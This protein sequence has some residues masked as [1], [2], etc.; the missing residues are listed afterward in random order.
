V[1]VPLKA[2]LTLWYVTLFAVIVAAWSVLVVV[3]VRADLYSNLDRSLSLRAAQIAQ[4]FKDADESDFPDII[5]AP[6]S[7]VPGPEAI[8]QL[9]SPAGV[10]LQY[11]GDAVASRTVAP[12]S[13]VRK[14]AASDAAQSKVTIRG[15]SYR[16][17]V[18]RVPSRNELILVG[19]QTNATDE[20]IR[21]LILIMLVSGPLVV[22]AAAAGGW[23]LA[24]RALQP[25][26]SMTSAAAGIGIDRLGDRVPVPPGK[27]ELSRLAATLNTMLGRLEDGVEAKRRLIA[28]ASHELQTPLAVMRTEL[29]VS[30]ASPSL[31]P[32]AVEVLEST[33][34]ET[35]RMT[36]IVRNLLTL[37]R[38]DEGTLQLLRARVDLRDVA[39]Q[40]ADS[41]EVLAREQGVGITVSGEPAI[42]DADAEFLR[43]VLVNLIE[44]AIKY[45]GEGAQV[46]IGSCV[47]D[48]N[49]IVSVSD[50]GPG[51][52]VRAQRLVFDRFYRL[53]RSRSK[54]NGGSG[55]GLAISQEIVEAHGG[56]IEL[57]SEPGHGST[58]TVS[59]PLARQPQVRR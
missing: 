16:L 21:L 39:Q 23:V 6:F 55:L 56:A 52:P 46:T 43:I 42:V 38:A 26:D 20:S 53:D 22:L 12:S 47:R 17:L 50:T 54:E 51:I 24:R 30:L 36:R 37:A 33:R 2:R 34:E 8:A 49:G 4:D 25:V 19:A 45:S 15:V 14:A 13:L 18:V 31:S 40:A 41:L 27:D 58:F 9:L 44:N 11:S 29:D 48:E 59:L 35:D 3:V 1:T 57:A 10:V 28:D 5:A 32:E 7:G